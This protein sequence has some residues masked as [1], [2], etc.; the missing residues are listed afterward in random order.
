[1]IVLLPESIWLS[2]FMNDLQALKI[3]SMVACQ[4]IKQVHKW[5]SKNEI[6]GRPR[7]QAEVLNEWANIWSKN[8]KKVTPTY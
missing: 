7:T 6:K 4:Q 1:M 3:V 5:R 8:L 2:P